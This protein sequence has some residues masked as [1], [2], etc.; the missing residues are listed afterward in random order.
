MEISEKIELNKKIRLYT[1]DNSF[2]LSLK[3]QL[4]LSKTLEKVEFGNKMLKILG[5]HYYLDL[6]KIE[7]FTN[8]PPPEDFSGISENHI[9]VVKY[10]MVKML[11]EILMTEDSQIDET[12]GMRS[13]EVSIPFK[14]SFNSLLNKKLIN[15]Y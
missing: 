2:L 14:L 8:V 12:L 11:V 3:K 13:T 9:S 1:G 10:D 7:E 6:D 15:K 5:E 4:K